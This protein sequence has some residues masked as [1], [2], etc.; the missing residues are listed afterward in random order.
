MQLK[1]VSQ[2]NVTTNIT[3]MAVNYNVSIASVPK[4]NL[5]Y[6]VTTNLKKSHLFIDNSKYKLYQRTENNYSM[7]NK[8][9]YRGKHWKYFQDWFVENNINE[10]IINYGIHEDDI[11]TNDIAFYL[12]FE[13]WDISYSDIIYQRNLNDCQYMLEKYIDDLRNHLK[14]NFVSMDLLRF[15]L[16]KIPGDDKYSYFISQNQL[17]TDY[18]DL[19]ISNTNYKFSENLPTTVNS[20]PYN[21]LITLLYG[22]IKCYTMNHLPMFV[23]LICNYIIGMLYIMQVQG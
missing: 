1:I 8:T 21:V 9:M 14:H 23:E 20:L 17:H 18:F 19:M 5:I 7:V 22:Y 11:N 13:G 2:L 4:L 3:V 16:N 6:S 12:C 15:R 10:F